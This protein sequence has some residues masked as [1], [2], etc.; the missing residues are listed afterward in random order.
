MK[1]LTLLFAILLISPSLFAEPT[2]IDPKGLLRDVNQFISANFS[3]ECE[4][5]TEYDWAKCDVKC[6]QKSCLLNSCPLQ[7]KEGVAGGI[8]KFKTVKCNTDTIGILF[9]PRFPTMGHQTWF[10]RTQF[11]RA[12]TSIQAA[13]GAYLPWT[14]SGRCPLF[15]NSGVGKL[16]FWTS[17]LTLENIQIED[18]KMR[19]GPAILALKI[20]GQIKLPIR[21]IQP[22][23][24]DTMVE[25]KFDLWMGKGVSYAEQFLRFDYDNKTIFKITNS[26][27]K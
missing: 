10:E 14:E 7:N 22:G 21:N 23:C 18:V 8:S 26:S 2:L 6:D 13:I 9:K 27:R 15:S 25:A 19:T 17:E 24:R 4:L 20:S 1:V 12:E 5:V 3:P 16:D 11:A